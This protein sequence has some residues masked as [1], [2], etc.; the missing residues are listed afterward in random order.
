M[1][2]V[3]QYIV[4]ALSCSGINGAIYRN[5]QEVKETDFPP[6]HAE[7]YVEDGHIK[8]LESKDGPEDA[9]L[10]KDIKKVGDASKIIAKMTDEAAINAFIEGDERPGVKK[11]AEDTIAKLPKG[12]ELSKD[13]EE[14]QAL[15]KISDMDTPESIN[16]FIKD[17][18][19]EAIV[20]ASKSKIEE[21][22]ND[23]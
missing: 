12:E 20:T 10:S 17:D 14:D 21:L 8:P 11:V 1:A 22:S 5:G 2:K 15:A 13:L 16:A 18:E 7:K 6:G 19:R 9:K 4:V 23:K 3:K